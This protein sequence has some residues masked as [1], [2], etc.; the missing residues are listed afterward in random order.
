MAPKYRDFFKMTQNDLDIFKVKQY[1]YA[2][3]INLEAQDF[4]RFTLW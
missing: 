2:Y 1:S 3:Y 4:N